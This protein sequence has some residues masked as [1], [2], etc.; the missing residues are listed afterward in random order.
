MRPNCV[1]RTTRDVT[2]LRLLFQAEIKSEIGSVSMFYRRIIGS[3][4]VLAHLSSCASP[5]SKTAAE[6]A[7]SITGIRYAY[8]MGEGDQ[9]LRVC[10]EYRADWPVT[11]RTLYLPLHAA[12]LKS[13]GAKKG[14]LYRHCEGNAACSTI[15]TNRQFPFE[16]GTLEP[17][18]LPAEDLSA[19]VKL[20]TGLVRR[21]PRDTDLDAMTPANITSP[22]VLLVMNESGETQPEV[23]F[24]SQAPTYQDKAPISLDF[25]SI[26]MDAETTPQINRYSSSPVEQALIYFVV[27]PVL[28]IASIPVRVWEKMTGKP[29]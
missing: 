8:L 17:G 7:G 20:T 26:P 28:L 14:G 10:L 25:G 19:G 3:V 2:R 23:L 13:V 6:S 22:T 15:A 12:V 29:Y 5:G 1:T 18:C 11:E 21:L 27:V 4:V 24:V 16:Q 9:R